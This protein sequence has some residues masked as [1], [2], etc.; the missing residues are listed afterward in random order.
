[1][2]RGSYRWDR[3]ARASGERLALVDAERP[4]ACWGIVDSLLDGRWY[5]VS[6][7]VPEPFRD[8][9]EGAMRAVEAAWGIDPSEVA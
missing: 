2:T 4:Y 1:M 5:V 3:S 6:P 8:S 9:A 7:D